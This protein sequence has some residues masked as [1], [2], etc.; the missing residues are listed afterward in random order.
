MP[1]PTVGDVRHGNTI[2]RRAKQFS[3]LAWKIKAI[4]I[5]RLRVIMHADA[6]NQNAS[7]SGT[8]AGCVIAA[9]DERM[10]QN[11]LSPW[12]P[13]VWKSYR[14]RRVTSSTLAAETQAQM[15]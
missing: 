6:F 8:P 4:S 15:D 7:K 1:R 14:L 12:S 10:L 13:L 11:E 5:D 9:T 2:V 3:N